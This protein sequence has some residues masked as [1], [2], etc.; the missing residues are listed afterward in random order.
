MFVQGF[1]YGRARPKID[2]PRLSLTYS[3]TLALRHLFLFFACGVFP[4]FQHRYI[5]AQKTL[6]LLTRGNKKI[7]KECNREKMTFEDL[8]EKVRTKLFTS[9]LQFSK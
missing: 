8:L 2:N 1:A 5:H 9:V 6:T 7:K 4:F 3:L